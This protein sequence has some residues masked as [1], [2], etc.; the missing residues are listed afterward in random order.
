MLVGHVM[1]QI[2]KAELIATM[3]ARH[4][5][6]NLQILHSTKMFL[7]FMS[8]AFIIV[9]ERHRT[10]VTFEWPN[11]K[12]DRDYVSTYMAVMLTAIIAHFT[13]MQVSNPHQMFPEIECC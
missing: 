7:T 5:G 3:R 8:R 12:M 6:H 13:Q 1:L 9:T 4:L 10:E 2:V 11:A